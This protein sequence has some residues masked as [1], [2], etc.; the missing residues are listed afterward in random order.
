VQASLSLAPTLPSFAAIGYFDGQNRL[1]CLRKMVY[2][3]IE[4]EMEHR[5][6]YHDN[7]ALKRAEIIDAD[8]KSHRSREGDSGYKAGLGEA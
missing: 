2:G 3:E 6:L 1:T 7:G 5:Y 4:I 8:G